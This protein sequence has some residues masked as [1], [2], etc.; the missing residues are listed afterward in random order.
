MNQTSLKHLS[1]HIPYSKLVRNLFPAESA[2]N[3]KIKI[4]H[5][6]VIEDGCLWEGISLMN[7]DES[8]GQCSTKF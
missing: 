4:T 5:H 3:I 2:N 1:S 7:F 8:V 6:R